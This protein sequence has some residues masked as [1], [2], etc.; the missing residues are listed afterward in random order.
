M[1]RFHAAAH[2]NRFRPNLVVTGCERFAEDGW[3]QVKIN[4]ITFNVA[5]PCERCAVTTTDQATG[6]RG[7]SR[8]K[9]SRCA[10]WRRI[11]EPAQKSILGRTLSIGLKEALLLGSRSML[12]R[13]PK[14]ER[15]IAL[16]V[17]CRMTPRSSDRQNER[18]K[19]GSMLVDGK[20][21]DDW[22]MKKRTDAQG[23][24]IRQ[25]S[26]FRHWITPDG[27][28]WPDRRRRLSG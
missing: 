11:V 3:Q 18:H 1:N 22:Q 13:L 5:K 24:F 17:W 15:Y 10:P 6:K 9:S 14:R 19:E 27:S 4:T 28:P 8:I 20:W 12:A 21:E 25:E 16:A 26:T 23:R 7:A 2:T